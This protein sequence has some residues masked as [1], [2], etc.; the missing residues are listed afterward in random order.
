MSGDK[1]I[2]FDGILFIFSII[3]S[4]VLEEFNQINFNK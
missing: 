2:N 3:F 4:F 1:L